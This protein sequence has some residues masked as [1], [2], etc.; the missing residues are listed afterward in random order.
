MQ[1][2]PSLTLWP[3]ALLIGLAFGATLQRSHFCTMGCISDAVLFGSL[4]RL[5]VWALAVAVALLGSQAIDGA[6]L[7]DLGQS[8]YLRTAPH[9]AFAV[10]LGGVMFGFGMV[11]AGGCVSRNLARLGAGSLKA[12]AALLATATAAGATW[13]LVP[14]PVLMA[15]AP[16]AAWMPLLG[17]AVSL[18]LLAFCLPDQRFRRSAPDLA[19]GSVLGI[20]IPL[21]WLATGLSRARP[22]SV[23]YL[24][25]DHA[26]FTL[27]L[28]LGTVLGAFAAARTARAFRIERFT[29]AG[30]L[31][32][33]LLGGALTGCG[34]ALASG[35][36]IGQGMTGV[37][38]LA[39]VSFLALAGMLGGAWWGVKHLE[40]GRLLPQL[41]PS[42]QI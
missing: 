31:R 3:W 17:V 9:R 26:D 20:L 5:R 32:R 21:G 25:L 8:T 34:G 29:A 36:T 30:D 42:R 13:V 2:A 22:E 27:P 4:R 6:G 10:A 35:C 23:N 12:L 19:T 18:A 14:P 1:D 16:S 11:Q 33:H 7:V 24:A 41:W 38:T 15:A 37:S 39:P 28:L 40:T